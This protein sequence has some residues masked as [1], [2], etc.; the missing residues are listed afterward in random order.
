ML[1][2]S[3]MVRWKHQRRKR[4]CERKLKKGYT[5]PAHLFASTFGKLGSDGILAALQEHGVGCEWFAGKFKELWDDKATSKHARLRMMNLLAGLVRQQEG[6]M[7]TVAGLGDR[8]LKEIEVE[9]RQVEA[10]ILEMVSGDES[11]FEGESEAVSDAESRDNAA[12]QRSPRQLQ[13][14]AEDRRLA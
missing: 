8:G 3:M 7:V 14:P 1:F 4:V 10:K 13:G 12:E 5:T 11:S 2:R 6:Q 9:A